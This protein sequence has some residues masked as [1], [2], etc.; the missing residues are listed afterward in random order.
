MIA[1]TLAVAI[2]AGAIMSQPQNDREARYI[3][4]V[5]QRIGACGFAANMVQ[6]EYQDLLQDHEVTIST[7][8]RELHEEQYACLAALVAE[9]GWIVTL[10]DETARSRFWEATQRVARVAA[11]RRLSERGLLDRLPT[12]DPGRQDLAAYARA[13]E[14][15]CGIDPGTVLLAQ[16][17]STLTMHP[18]NDDQLSFA[19][20]SCLMDAVSASNLHE[21][22][23]FFGF[24][25]NA[26]DD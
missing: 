19:D 24:V 17:S 18:L 9:T 8:A 4:E 2:A 14:E 23:V 10:A 15:L 12:Y 13:V 6:V 16:S 3:Q 26:I 20:L 25:G 1:L 5:R 22:S 7:K 11:R 21:H